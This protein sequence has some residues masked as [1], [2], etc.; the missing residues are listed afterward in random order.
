[1]PMDLHTHEALGLHLATPAE[2]NGRSNNDVLASLSH[3]D[4]EQ[5]EPCPESLES[6]AIPTGQFYKFKDWSSSSAYP[7][8]RR[9]LAVH[10]PAE[11][12][13]KPYAI[14]IFNDGA[15]YASKNGTA[16]VTQVLDTLHAQR[17]IPPTVAVFVNPGLPAG[18]PAGSPTASYTPEATQRS[19]EYDALTPAYGRFLLD[20]VLPFVAGELDINL[21]RDPEHRTVAG[22]SSGGIAAFSAA[23]FH[24]DEFRRVLSHCGSYT[25]ILGGH[26]Y[27]YLVRATPRK[28]IRVY[29][30]SGEQDCTTIFGDWATAN[31]AMAKALGY[32]GYDFHF[33]FGQGGH[34]LRHAGAVMADS[35]RWLWR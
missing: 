34:T 24:P 30:Q 22:I 12:S 5:Y 14:A 28:P 1:M 23:W 35:L 4:D 2:V 19:L 21:T 32:A 17:E 11:A 27:P 29:L 18:T 15:A 16:R 33:E 6:S 9:D 13:D 31:M 10:L 26:N 7:G 3:P 8:T 20:E 25:N